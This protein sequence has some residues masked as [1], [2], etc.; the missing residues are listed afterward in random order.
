MIYSATLLGKNADN[1]PRIFMFHS[2]LPENLATEIVKTL[3]ELS[4]TTGTK[5]FFTPTDILIKCINEDNR[6]EPLVI[7]MIDH[8][9][10]EDRILLS[11]SSFDIPTDDLKERFLHVKKNVNI[12][13]HMLSPKKDG[14]SL[15]GNL[16]DFLRDTLN[17]PKAPYL[18]S[19][20]L[21]ER[22]S[23]PHIRW[24][25]IPPLESLM[26]LVRKTNDIL[27][28][29]N[30]NCVMDIVQDTYSEGRPVFKIT[31]YS[32]NGEINDVKE[33]DTQKAF[34]FMESILE[35]EKGFLPLLA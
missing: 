34:F 24:D 28:K 4:R 18:A 8:S 9:G 21:G 30:K 27:K 31:K 15:F 25:G 6:D 14:Q 5:I 22:A 7:R 10:T 1:T 23:S 17:E 29:N 32:D 26:E 13:W 11:V 2:V 16:V 12:P 20:I 35:E 33:L 3:K 19:L